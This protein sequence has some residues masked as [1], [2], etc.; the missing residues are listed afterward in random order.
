M[1]FL[2]KKKGIN[3]FNE[4]LNNLIFVFESTLRSNMEIKHYFISKV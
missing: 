2:K 4:I 1:H 3:S